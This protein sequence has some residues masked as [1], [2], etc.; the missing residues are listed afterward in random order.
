[1]KNNENKNFLEL[2][3]MREQ[4]QVLKATLDEQIQVNE[5]LMLKQLKKNS[6]AIEA[7][8]TGVLVAAILAIYPIISYSRMFGLTKLLTITVITVMLID[9]LYNYWVT[10]MV[11]NEDL[12]NGHVGDVLTTMLKVKRITRIGISAEIVIDIVL[13]LWIGYETIW[14]PKL[15]F[16]PH[17]TQTK[18]IIGFIVGILLGIILATWMYRKHTKAIDEMT[19]TLNGRLG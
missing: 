13:I 8:G 15:P 2:E 3:D 4:M 11:K 5:E 14:G 16:F 7:N 6:H 1:M 18:V 9:G 19:E 17:E 12:S 10:H